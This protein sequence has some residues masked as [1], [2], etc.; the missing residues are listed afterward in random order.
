MNEEKS[1]ADKATFSL[2]NFG[3]FWGKTH[4]LSK[5]CL[6]FGDQLLIF[7]VGDKKW[8]I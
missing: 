3:K 2:H 6:S 1:F 8:A 5:S 7:F 4:F